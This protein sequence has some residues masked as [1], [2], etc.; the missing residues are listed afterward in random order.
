MTA[1]RPLSLWS[2]AIGGH[3]GIEFESHS[4]E[5]DWMREH[6][7]PVNGEIATHE[8]ADEVVERCLWW[9]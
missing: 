3:E 8:N 6:G 7:F 9:E 4:H 1:S 2:Y 5:L